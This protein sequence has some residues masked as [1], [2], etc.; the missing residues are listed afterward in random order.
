MM[1]STRV[2]ISSCESCSLDDRLRQHYH[3]IKRC[4][5]G[6]MAMILEGTDRN[7]KRPVIIKAFSKAK[8]TASMRDKIDRELTALKAAA[9]CQG[10]VKMLNTIEDVEHQ[11]V[12]LENVPGYTLIELMAANEGRLH[13]NRCV[14][15]V[16]YPLLRAL[17]ALHELGIVHR[18]LK[19]EHIMCSYGVIKLL[20]FCESAHQGT[21]QCLNHRVGQLEYMAP[22]VLC[23]PSAEEIFHQVLFKGMAENELPQYDEKADVWSVGAVIFEALTGQQPFLAD[24]AQDMTRLHASLQEDIGP[25]GIPAVLNHHLLSPLAKQFLTA[26]LQV[27]PAL[28]PSAAQLLQHTWVAKHTTGHNSQWLLPSPP[29]SQVSSASSY[30]H[31]LSVSGAAAKLPSLDAVMTTASREP[32][33]LPVR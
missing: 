28:R 14:V 27:D 31:H 15:E 12:I 23:K 4:H 29:S 17:G 22:E 3:R 20:D 9:G 13:E 33:T 24:N 25:D 11:Y 18:N 5:R 21:Q 6:K 16:V 32:L 26:A 10:V 30:G 19:P 8:M 2:S 7:T 1:Q